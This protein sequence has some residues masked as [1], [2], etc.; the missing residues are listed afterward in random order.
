MYIVHLEKPVYISVPSLY[1]V[2]LEFGVD[3]LKGGHQW[4]VEFQVYEVIGVRYVVL[5]SESALSLKACML[6]ILRH[7]REVD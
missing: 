7:L 2:H 1:I 5:L 6:H 4:E 3:E